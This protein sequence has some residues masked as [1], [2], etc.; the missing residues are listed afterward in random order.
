M[1]T[2]IAGVIEMR[3]LGRHG[4]CGC[5]GMARI[6]RDGDGP[7]CRLGDL[8]AEVDWRDQVEDPIPF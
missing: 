7:H 5:T 6:S 8:C 3:V 1:V 4:V 2:V